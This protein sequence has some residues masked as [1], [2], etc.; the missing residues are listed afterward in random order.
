MLKMKILKEDFENNYNTRYVDVTGVAKEKFLVSDA[1]D[2]WRLD[3][4][5]GKYMYLAQLETHGHVKNGLYHTH[6]PHGVT[7]PTAKVVAHA[8]VDG[9]APGRDRIIF[10]DGNKQNDKAD[11]LVWATYKEVMQNYFAK[12]KA[13]EEEQRERDGY[14]LVSS[15]AKSDEIYAQIEAEDDS[16][17]FVRPEKPCDD[18]FWDEDIRDWVIFS[19]EPTERK[20]V[21]QSNYEV[22]EKDEKAQA[23]AANKQ[24]RSAYKWGNGKD[25]NEEGEF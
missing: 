16:L 19:K 21:D 24:L 1:G 8:F 3:R 20:W 10:K 18:A 22:S 6:F 9:Y 25:Y 17:T 5:D 4:F 23:V 12:K 2:V 11:N 15:K 13:D 14:V 7:I